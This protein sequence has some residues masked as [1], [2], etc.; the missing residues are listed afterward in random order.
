MIVAHHV[1][2]FSPPPDRPVVATI[3]TFDGL[4]RGHQEIMRQ[5]GELARARNGL[6]TVITFHPHP[7][8]VIAPERAPRLLLTGQQ[9]LDRLEELGVE[10]VVVLP[11][12][13]QLAAMPAEAFA[14]D[15][16]GD[17]LGVR[18]I[19]VGPDFRFGR[20]R[21]GDPDLLA[22]I[23][24]QAGFRARAL[25]PVVD[26]DERI[27]ASRIRREL[28]RGHVAEA[29]RL[30]GRPFSLVGT[31]VHG[32]GRGR[33]VLLPT[34]NL[35]PE[36]EFLPERGVYVTRTRHAA[37]TLHGL[38][39]LGI[40]PTFGEERLTVETFLSG[41]AGDLYGARIELEFL[42]RLRPE[43]KFNTP[44]DLMD[45]IFR[46][47]EQFEAYCRSHGIPIERPGEDAR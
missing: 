36:N 37:R 31:V 44:G 5:L 22:R 15:L 42:D 40:R 12:D 9:K 17:A 27:S 24:E 2:E 33:Q 7:L 23:G 1:E 11:F 43:R 38:T 8:R 47:I 32:E 10:A 18:E 14:R 13:R 28:E 19:L 16:L 46:D 20:G 3:G 29:A 45:Q 6:S 35:A 26:G 21:A 30:L 34:A 41:F 25:E 39:N 4:H